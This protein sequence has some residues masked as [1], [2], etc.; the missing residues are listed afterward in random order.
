MSTTVKAFTARKQHRCNTA[1]RE[2]HTIAPGHRYL[3]HTA[4]PD[5][6]INTSDRP[7]TLTEC[8]ACAEERDPSAGLL[9]A[10]AC[11]TFCCANVPCAR[12][13]KHDDD[14]SC[15]QCVRRRTPETR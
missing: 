9:V 6:E 10:G 11:T 2:A 7:Y 8:V 4:F 14:H 3:R 12:P 15:G 13:A 1:F 5:G